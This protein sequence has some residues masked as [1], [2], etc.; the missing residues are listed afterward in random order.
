MANYIAEDLG[1]TPP[2]K[3]TLATSH[4]TWLEDISGKGHSKSNN[5]IWLSVASGEVLSVQIP[6]IPICTDLLVI[7]T[8]RHTNMVFTY[9]ATALSRAQA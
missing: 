9:D 7:G 5:A 1:P 6:S 4:S 3:C 8:S 2:M